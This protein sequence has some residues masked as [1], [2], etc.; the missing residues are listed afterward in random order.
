[1]VR[2]FGSGKFWSSHF[3]MREYSRK[4][5]L[6]PEHQNHNQSLST[7]EAITCL[8]MPQFHR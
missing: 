8:E 6:E 7:Q 4:Y 3:S 1:M 2:N 5:E